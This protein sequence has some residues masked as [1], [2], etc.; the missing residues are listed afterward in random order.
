[1]NEATPNHLG[2]TA[3][4]REYLV[5]EGLEP[6]D[7]DAQLQ[8]LQSEN[9]YLTLNRAC[10]LGDGLRRFD[11]QEREHLA[12]TYRAWRQTH[13]A[14]RFIPASGAA[15][16][17]FAA[18]DSLRR[19]SPTPSFDALKSLA[20]KNAD[21]K[22]CWMILSQLDKFPF[23]FA[24]R[25]ALGIGQEPWPAVFASQGLKAV[26]TAMLDTPGLGLMDLP[27][28]L[29][30][31]H[32]TAEGNHTA[33]HA[34]VLET[35]SLAAN[36]QGICRLHFTVSPEHQVLFIAA[37]E[38]AAQVLAQRG[39]KLEV[40]F[41]EQSPAT[42]TLSTL[43]GAL[44]RDAAGHP[45]LRPGGHGSLLRNLESVA[46]DLVFVKNIDNV[47]REEDLPEAE[48]WH[49]ALA[50]HLLAL[51]ESAHG[52][53]RA[54]EFNALENTADT[55][56][57]SNKIEIANKALAWLA[58]VTGQPLP[59]AIRQ[60]ES[61]EKI[62]LA[63]QALHRPIRVC[64]MVKNE[65]EPGGGPFFAASGHGE[66]TSQIVEAAQVNTSDATQKNILGQATHFN[67]VDFVCALRD[68]RGQ[69]YRLSDYADEKAWFL[70][71]KPKGTSWLTVLER[72]GLWNG[73]MAHWL[74]V[75][76][77]IPLALF[78]PVKTLADLLRPA[79]QGKA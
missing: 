40:G 68:H 21:A 26:V 28:A 30:P 15:S 20:E 42:R 66:P 71:R 16:R 39:Q 59:L 72:P 34:Q 32:R 69:P 9:L 36:A 2:L 63:Y 13:T 46:A 23:A 64:G 18:L 78:N 60:A 41:S 29:I 37:C 55:T 47:A 57:T 7:I 76:V 53:L 5:R 58:Q 24:L 8:L 12:A 1:M 77:E 62:R 52:F 61:Q 4:D 31:F 3:A 35:A 50:G 49:A 11:T 22:T 54:L 25:K 70:A 43:D 19:Q 10:T 33:L 73:A 75:F 74:T 27:K 65:G 14:S 45:A 51:Q 67:P 6:A 48:A 79:H 38:K 56:I 17:L 44:V